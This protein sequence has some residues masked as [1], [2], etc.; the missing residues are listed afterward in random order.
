MIVWSFV[1]ALKS[2]WLFL[3]I[4]VR[5]SGRPVRSYFEG[6]G[7]APQVLRI[8]PENEGSPMWTECHFRQIKRPCEISL[9]CLAIPRPFALKSYPVVEHSRLCQSLHTDLMQPIRSCSEGSLKE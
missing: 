9:F 4:L 1:R 5:A 8:T 2:G 6:K 3:V 7:R